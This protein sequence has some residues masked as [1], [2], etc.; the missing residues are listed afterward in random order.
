MNVFFFGQET[1]FERVYGI[2]IHKM[3]PTM[4]TFWVKGPSISVEE[5]PHIQGAVSLF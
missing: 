1:V 4:L 2:C 5:H 3:A